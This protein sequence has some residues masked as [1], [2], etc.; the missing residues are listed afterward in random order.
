MVDT[1]LMATL[2][3]FP[4]MHQTYNVPFV[5]STPETESTHKSPPFTT[6]KLDGTLPTPSTS[7]YPWNPMSD[8]SFAAAAQPTIPSSSDVSSKVYGVY[9]ASAYIKA[10]E[11][12]ASSIEIVYP[13]HTLSKAGSVKTQGH[14]D[15]A[16]SL[17]LPPPVSYP[18]P[19]QPMTPKPPSSIASSSSSSPSP[20][21]S[22]P[23]TSL[24]PILSCAN[25]KTTNTPLW[26][27]NPLIKSPASGEMGD[28]LCNAC[29]LFFKLH[30]VLR[31][32]SM[33]TD[34]SKKAAAAAAAAGISTSGFSHAKGLADRKAVKM[35]GGVALEGMAGIGVKRR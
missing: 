14:L 15:F 28:P 30:G 33:K 23:T 34:G 32:I 21:Y 31:P 18:R 11:M 5:Y 17:L 13:S 24:T 2:L 20:S 12:V 10:E 26:R 1:S 16:S 19:S 35:A 27:R 7:P 8:S 9:Q 6:L 3:P 25:C 4:D 22:P 29:G